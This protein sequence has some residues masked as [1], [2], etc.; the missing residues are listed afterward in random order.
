MTTDGYINGPAA[1]KWYEA[2]NPL[3]GY[4]GFGKH[5]ICLD[6]IDGYPPSPTTANPL[7]STSISHA[8][9]MSSFASVN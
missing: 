5:C 9:L 2:R 7:S 6:V 3:L 4:D 8:Y 1:D